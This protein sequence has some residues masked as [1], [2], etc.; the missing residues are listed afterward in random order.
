MSLVELEAC[1]GIIKGGNYEHMSEIHR[2]EE[3]VGNEIASIKRRLSELDHELD[4][5]KAAA[6][7][8]AAEAVAAVP[9]TLTAAAPSP[10]DDEDDEEEKDEEDEEDEEEEETEEDTPY[11]RT[12]NGVTYY[13][14]DEYVQAKR[15]HNH[16]VLVSKGLLSAKAAIDEERMVKATL[17]PRE[18][19]RKRS[20]DDNSTAQVSRRKS[21][22]LQGKSSPDTYVVS[23]SSRKLIIAVPAQGINAEVINTEGIDDTSESSLDDVTPQEPT[24]TRPQ[25]TKD[26]TSPK[27]FVIDLSDVPPQPPIP[28]LPR[29]IKDGG[30]KYTGVYFDKVRK[31]WKAQIKI[32]GTHCTLGRFNDEEAAGVAYATALFK[33]KGGVERPP[34]PSK[35]DVS[36]VPPQEP[37][38]KLPRHIKDGGSKYTGVYFDKGSNKWRANIHIDGDRHHIGLF[39]DEEAAGVAYAEVNYKY[40]GGVNPGSGNPRDH[41]WKPPKKRA[42][43]S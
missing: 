3:D 27:K 6:A 18:G 5:I 37:F 40:R 26:G 4:E 32:D 36:D 1:L 22:R 25:D 21:P 34:K 23:D 33:Y 28:K 16:D 20:N 2:T 9:A 17:R 12:F 7:A 43:R 10:E 24:L 11:T 42:R 8:A 29:R 41:E 35:F 30:S 31:K 13:S 39:E 38:L 15:Q 14:Y 19:K